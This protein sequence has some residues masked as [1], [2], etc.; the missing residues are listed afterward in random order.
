MSSACDVDE[1]PHVF[2]C[3]RRV[4]SEVR[5]DDATGLHRRIA[6]RVSN[7]YAPIEERR[8]E[9][10]VQQ[11]VVHGCVRQIAKKIRLTVEQ[12]LDVLESR[13]E[14]FVEA[15]ALMKGGRDVQRI[16]ALGG[17]EQLTEAAVMTPPHLVSHAK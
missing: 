13:A 10:T 5:D 17:V 4:L 3:W 15:R 14:L 9:R 16:G 7:A 8:E 2:E 6:A 12:R 11:P 1:T